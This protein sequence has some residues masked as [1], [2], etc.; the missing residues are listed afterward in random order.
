MTRKYSISV[1][2]VEKLASLCFESFDKVHE[3]RKY[4]ILLATPINTTHNVL[5]AHAHNLAQFVGKDR[6]Q[7]A[8]GIHGVH[9]HIDAAARGVCAL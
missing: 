6:Q 8:C 9:M 1:D 3:R 5:C 7:T 2:I 4:C